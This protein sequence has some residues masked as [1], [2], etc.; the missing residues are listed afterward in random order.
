MRLKLTPMPTYRRRD[1][2]SF[3]Y[4][5]DKV[6]GLLCG[7]PNRAHYWSSPYVSTIRVAN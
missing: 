4:A 6:H 7:R 1:A 2:L 5:R 3:N